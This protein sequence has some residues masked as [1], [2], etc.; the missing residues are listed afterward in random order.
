LRDFRLI[1]NH[2]ENAEIWAPGYKNGLLSSNV[3]MSRDNGWRASYP[4]G[5]VTDAAV[6]SVER[7][8]LF[9]WAWP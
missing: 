8:G 9:I 7:I 1:Q 5:R 2:P 6:G 4:A 3:A